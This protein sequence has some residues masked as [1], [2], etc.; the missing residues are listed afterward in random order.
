MKCRIISAAALV[1][2]AF[3]SSSLGR[4]QTPFYQGKTITILAGTGAGNVY[5]LYARLF[6]RHM[7][8]YIP[9]NPDIIVQNMA[10]AASMIAA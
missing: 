1:V 8:K 7:G 3:F 5:D 9:G 2:F 4:A 10:G 6:A